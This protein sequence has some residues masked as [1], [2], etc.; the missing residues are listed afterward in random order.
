[1]R[2]APPCIRP[3]RRNGKSAS[4]IS[5]SPS[6]SHRIQ[7]CMSAAHTG[8]ILLRCAGASRVSDRFDDNLKE[9]AVD[10]V[11]LA[12]S[13]AAYATVE[14]GVEIYA[15]L[16]SREV[17][18]VDTTVLARTAQRAGHLVDLRGVRMGAV[19]L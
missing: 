12:E 6:R 15:Y 8:G 2:T 17:G 5:R 16:F 9:L 4:R 19:R 3:V 1:M 7:G 14:V 13:V 11:P 18:A 10:C